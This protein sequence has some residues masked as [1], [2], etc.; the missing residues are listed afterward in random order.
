MTVYTIGYQDS[1]IDDFVSFLA[2]KKIE[3]IVDV[4]KNPVSRKKGFSKNKLAAALAEKKID[5]C[6]FPELGVPQA[7]RQADHSH[8]ITREKMFRDY[9]EKILP[10]RKHA[11][12]DVLAHIKAKSVAL[13]CFEHAA[14]DCHRLHLARRLKQTAK[15]LK[16]VNLEPPISS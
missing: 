15:R 12:A 16:I 9:D 6:H 10:V 13:L 1:N 4:R 14:E 8:R 5:Y 11:V 3:E 7:W 2:R